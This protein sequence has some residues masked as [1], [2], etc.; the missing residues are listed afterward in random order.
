MKN[1]L[2]VYIVQ[3]GE[4]SQYFKITIWSSH[5]GA[6]ETN[7]TSI[8]EGASW[9]PGLTQWVVDLVSGVAMSCAVG[10]RHGLDGIGWQL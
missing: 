9:I 2:Q 7:P 10:H 3:H 8:P 6:A 4:Y 1:K 5:C